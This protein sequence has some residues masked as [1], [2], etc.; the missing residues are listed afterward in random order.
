[1]RARASRRCEQLYL[2]RNGIGAAGA[3]M[4]ADALM[5]NRTLRVLGLD[6]NSIGDEGAAAMARALATNRSLTRVCL[7]GHRRPPLGEDR[8]VG[9]ASAL[10]AH[11]L[12]SRVTR[13]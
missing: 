8:V 13:R 7:F 9:M 1:M 12:P 4:L 2:S 10:H 6:S 5:A 3:A 11:V